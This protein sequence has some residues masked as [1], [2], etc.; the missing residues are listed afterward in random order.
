MQDNPSS[1]AL[2]APRE[3]QAGPQPVLREVA[4]DTHQRRAVRAAGVWEGG[5]DVSL[6]AASVWME[7]LPGRL[8]E[9]AAEQGEGV[10]LGDDLEGG[11]Q[12]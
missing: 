12:L 10:S 6:R 11:G 2:Y 5:A 9:G 3:G 8:Q 4:R 1:R 7:T